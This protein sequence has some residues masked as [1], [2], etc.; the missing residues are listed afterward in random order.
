MNK[1][2]AS[3]SR[4]VHSEAQLVD[5]VQEI[6]KKLKQVLEELAGVKQRLLALERR[7]RASVSPPHQVQAYK[8]RDAL[9]GAYQIEPLTPALRQTY[10]IVKELTQSPGSWVSL[11]EIVANSPRSSIT[12]SAYVKT[13][14]KAGHLTRKARLTKT[15]RGRKVRTYVYRPRT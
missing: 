14:H 2:K 13:L 12:E 9:L 11:R 6:D 10:Q 8:D 7:N 1:R 5:S 3:V 4:S 15:P